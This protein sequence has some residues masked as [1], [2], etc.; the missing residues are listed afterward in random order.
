MKSN[1]LLRQIFNLFGSRAWTSV[2]VPSGHMQLC[3]RSAIGWFNTGKIL[4]GLMGVL[5]ANVWVAPSLH[6]GISYTAGTEIAW[7]PGSVVSVPIT[8]NSTLTGNDVYWVSASFN[9]TWNSSV[10][11]LQSISPVSVTL[12]DSGIPLSLTA[13]FQ[14]HNDIG[15]LNFLWSDPTQNGY[16]VPQNFTLFTVNFTAIGGWGSSTAVS[17]ASVS[18]VGLTDSTGQDLI[19]LAVN[20]VNNGFVSVIPEPI[21]WGLG[22]FAC[23]FIGGATVR[24]VSHR[25]MALQ[26][27]QTV[28]PDELGA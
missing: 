21:N 13:N 26:S 20:P 14:Q 4:L 15:Q 16:L 2:Q 8:V 24:W 6:A 11:S 25:K 18:K 7:P 9:L 12:G 1:C 17:F 27:E 3:Q 10:L 28:A 22:L 5:V 19:G 23:V